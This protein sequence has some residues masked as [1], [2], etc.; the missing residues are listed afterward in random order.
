MKLLTWERQQPT[1]DQFTAYQGLYDHFNKEL[2]SG[3]LPSIILNFSRH[4]GACGF[5]AANRWTQGAV[6]THEISLNPTYLAKADFQDV[7]QTLVHEQAHQLQYTFGKPSRTGYHNTEWSDK[8]IEVGLMPSTTGQPGGKIT[9]QKM[10]DYMI[11]GGKFEEVYKNLP[12]ALRLPWKAA[13]EHTTVSFPITTISTGA[14]AVV[15]DSP[16]P[17]KSKIKY[18]CPTCKANA[19][20][21]PELNL[22]CGDCNAK[23]EVKEKK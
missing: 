23:M 9:G 2:F 3:I 7:C 18:T 11:E 8:M 20:G 19:W 16:E 15:A 1:N 5:F 22:I 12:A 6:K 4:A 21:K 13:K 17:K 10:S 14:D